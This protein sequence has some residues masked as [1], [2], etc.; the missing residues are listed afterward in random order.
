MMKIVLSHV[1]I[2]IVHC[3]VEKSV[4][5]VPIASHRNDQRSTIG[6]E[7]FLGFMTVLQFGLGI[8]LYSLPIPAGC[9]INPEMDLGGL[10][11]VYFYG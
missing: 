1:A 8:L 4:K 2:G 5:S 3:P 6:Y 11:G 7:N 10:V 9:V